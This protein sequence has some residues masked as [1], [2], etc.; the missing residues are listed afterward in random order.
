MDMGVFG[1][2]PQV[3]GIVNVTPD[4]FS[5]GGRF[6]G[7][8]QAIDAGVR[9]VEEGADLVDVG[10]ESTR[11]GSEPVPL[12]EE[13]RRVMPVVEGLCRAGLRVSIDTYK[14]RVAKEAV[15]AGALV[16]NDVRA[17]AEEGMAEVCARS[18]C[19]VCL[20]HMRGRPATMQRDPSYRDVAGEVRSFLM[21]RAELAQAAG[22]QRARI[23]IDP[24]IGFGKT[25]EH[26]LTLIGNLDAFVGTGFPVL[27]GVSRKGFIGR[28][29]GDVGHPAPI[30]DRL[31]GTLTIHVVSLMAGVQV[32]RT[33]D[34][35]EA[36]AVVK[37]MRAL[38]IEGPRPSRSSNALI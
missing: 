9:I 35:R 4:S 1:A 28:I 29:L 20:M 5:D 30:A 38:G 16:V 37:M 25:D 13:L 6:S 11:P 33:H 12:D 17:L 27:L 36:V 26:N 23:W 34:V 32:L 10:G 7:P 19:T 21:E 15:D 31:P 18:G 8:Q 14:S 2:G 22:I 3:M 24:G